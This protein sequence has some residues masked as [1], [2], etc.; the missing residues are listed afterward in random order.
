MIIFYRFAEIWYAAA[1]AEML[2]EKNTVRSLK[3]TVVK[4]KIHDKKLYIGA[5][6][7]SIE[8]DD[9]TSFSPC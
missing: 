1:Y 8:F 2:W 7:A 4:N 9:M 5:S 6:F 3:S